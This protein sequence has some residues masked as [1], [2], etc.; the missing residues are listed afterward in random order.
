MSLMLNLEDLEGFKRDVWGYTLSLMIDSKQYGDA[1]MNMP[2]EL[3][4]TFLSTFPWL[5][6]RG[7]FRAPFFA[8]TRARTSYL[9]P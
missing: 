1:S 2:S 3:L 6:Y 5:E 7:S 4:L 9:R 8:G